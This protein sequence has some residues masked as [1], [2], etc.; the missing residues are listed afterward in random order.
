MALMEGNGIEGVQEKIRD[1]YL[2]AFIA[3]YKVWPI[4]QFVNFRFLPLQ[5][6]LPFVSTVGILWNGYLSWLNNIAKVD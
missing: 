4:V 1:A 3:N 6:R 5:Y 2:P